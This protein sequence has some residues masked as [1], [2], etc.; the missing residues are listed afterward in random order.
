MSEY[1]RYVHHGQRVWVRKDLRGKH[2]DVC[3]C[4]AC[5]KFAPNEDGNCILAQTNY[6]FCVRTGLVTP[7]WECP[8]FEEASDEPQ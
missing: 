7:V 8:V 3:L 1:V 2:R 4:L 5:A 6:E